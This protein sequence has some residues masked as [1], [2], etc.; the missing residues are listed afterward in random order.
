MN[1]NTKDLK[2]KTLQVE[3]NFSLNDDQKLAKLKELG[4][5]INIDKENN[6]GSIS[7]QMI[8]FM[9]GALYIIDECNESW[10]DH[11]E[12]RKALGCL[13]CEI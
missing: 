9:T 7:E 1:N 3:T 10:C 6:D 13:C 11:C 2:I 5:I 4:D 8:A 12:V